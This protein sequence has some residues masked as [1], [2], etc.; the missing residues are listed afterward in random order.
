M[1][2]HQFSRHFSSTA[3]RCQSA[4]FSPVRRKTDNVKPSSAVIISLT[5]LVSLL[6]CF[7]ACVVAVNASKQHNSFNFLLLEYSAPFAE[8]ICIH[9]KLLAQASSLSRIFAHNHQHN[10]IHTHIYA[11]MLHATN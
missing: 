1:G 6:S 11:Y 2:F 8:Y 4:P 3:R 5:N 9:G 7:G 10:H